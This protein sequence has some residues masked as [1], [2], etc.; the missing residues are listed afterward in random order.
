MRERESR[1]ARDIKLTNEQIQRKIAGAD[2]AAIATAG[3]E[4]D[5][6]QK[7]LKPLLEAN[8][9]W[10]TGHALDMRPEE[11]EKE[12]HAAR[13]LTSILDLCE[14]T[15][16]TEDDLREQAEKLQRMLEKAGAGMEP[17]P[18]EG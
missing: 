11:F 18:G 4:T 8:I 6:W 13:K 10:F 14:S 15:F 1:R 12:Q 7:F 16:G 9:E 5:F 17:D 2:A 3:A